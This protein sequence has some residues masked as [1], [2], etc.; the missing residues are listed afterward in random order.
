MK[1]KNL[2]WKNLWDERL[3]TLESLYGKSA[4]VVGHAVVP[5]EF[6]PEIGGAAILFTSTSGSPAVFQ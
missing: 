3:L 6:G 5:F 1:D 4:D 2:E